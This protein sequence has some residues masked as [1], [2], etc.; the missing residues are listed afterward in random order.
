MSALRLGTTISMSGLDTMA[1]MTQ[2]NSNKAT[3]FPSTSLTWLNFEISIEIRLPAYVKNCSIKSEKFYRTRKN[4]AHSDK[5]PRSKEDSAKKRK[6][7]KRKLRRKK[8]K[9]K[10]LNGNTRLDFFSVNELK[11]DKENEK[12]K[13]PRDRIRGVKQS[14][15]HIRSEN[16]IDPNQAHSAYADQ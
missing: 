7:C 3:I 15:I 5:M 11:P 16:G 14:Q 8:G 6:V 2:I 10:R 4:F 1:F 9:S 13:N 12:S